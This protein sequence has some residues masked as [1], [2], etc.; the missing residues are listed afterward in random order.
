MEEG[1][2][3][4]DVGEAFDEESVMVGLSW[5]DAFCRSRCVVGIIQIAT[6]LR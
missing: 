4:E 5:K 3:E 6:R 1:E 2:A